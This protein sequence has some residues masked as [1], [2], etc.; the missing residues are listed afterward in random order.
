MIKTEIEIAI[1]PHLI[2][3]LLRVDSFFC[4]AECK[5]ICKNTNAIC[6]TIYCSLQ[7]LSQYFMCA[8][9]RVVLT[10]KKNIHT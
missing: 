4:L 9:E 3:V 1:E 7:S 8:D 6:I 2:S 5:T 10:H